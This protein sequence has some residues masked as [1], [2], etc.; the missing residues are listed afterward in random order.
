MLLYFSLLSTSIRSHCFA[1]FS[2]TEH[3]SF[4]YSPYLICFN[5]KT[6]VWT[7]FVGTYMVFTFFIPCIVI[8]LCNVDQQNEL[9]ELMFWFNSCLLR[10]SNILCSASRRLYCTSSLIC[11]VFHAFMQAVFL[12]E[13]LW[14]TS[15]NLVGCLHKRM[16]KITYRAVSTIYSSWWWT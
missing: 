1:C 2:L 5:T 13:G 7:D 14:S 15:F 8:K 10:V 3:R 9:F 6:C 11:Y 4:A 12:G 16:D